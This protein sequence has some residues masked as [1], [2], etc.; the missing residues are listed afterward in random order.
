[1]ARGRCRKEFGVPTGGASKRD[2]KLLAQIAD[3]GAQFLVRLGSTRRL[4]TCD[5]LPD[6][7]YLTRIRHVTVRV[8]DAEITAAC[9]NGSTVHDGYRLVTTLLDPAL[10]PA[11]QLVRLYHERWEI[12]SAYYALRHTLMQGRV[13]RSGDPVGVEQEVW[14]LLTLYQLLRTAMVDAVES[15]PGTD[16]DRASFTVALEA[17]RDQLVTG[18]GALGEDSDLVGRIGEA[19]LAHLLPA[20]RAR[21]SARRVKCPLSRYAY[22]DPEET[23]PLSSTRV[24]SLVISI[25]TVQPTTPSFISRRHPFPTVTPPPKP[26]EPS[27]IDRAYAVLRLAPGRRWGARELARSIGVDNVSSFA[28]LLARWARHGLIHKPQAGVYML[29]DDP[30]ETPPLPVPPSIAPG[31]SRLEGALAVL[32]SAPWHSWTAREVAPALGITNV[33]SLN[34]QMARWAREGLMTRT[35]RGAYALASSPPTSPRPTE[36]HLLTCENTA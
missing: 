4:P 14:A 31:T 11:E 2:G 13:L 33:A 1:M 6:G 35:R 9:T 26:R 28:V 34:V 32:R 5:R 8:I 3:T 18:H 15:R 10:D 23:R 27:L 7:S 19:V 12:E 22:P 20:R 21:I 17:A 36:K 25:H 29:L 16:P 30:T 24:G